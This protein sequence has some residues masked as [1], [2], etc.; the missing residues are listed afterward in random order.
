M[1][2][3]ITMLK[4]VLGRV[5]FVL[6]PLQEESVLHLFSQMLKG[7]EYARDP[8]VQQ[9]EWATTTPPSYLSKSPRCIRVISYIAISK[10]RTCN[11]TAGSCNRDITVEKSRISQGVFFSVVCLL[12]P[13][14]LQSSKPRLLDMEH[15]S[16]KARA[17]TLWPHHIISIWYEK[18]FKWSQSI[19]NYLKSQNIVANQYGTNS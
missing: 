18:H 3:Y 5:A 17:L 4:M 15:R 16:V 2:D 1:I 12:N 19:L 13:F 11:L 10:R 8:M 14:D 6:R 7:M 9:Q